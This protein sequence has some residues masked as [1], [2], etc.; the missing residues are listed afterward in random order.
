[1]DRIPFRG[2]LPV[3]SWFSIVHWHNMG[4]LFGFLSN[5]SAG[6]YVFLIIPIVIMAALGYYLVAYRHSLWS[7][8]GLTLVLSGAI[9]NMYDRIVFGYV[10]DFLDVFYRGFHWP[11]FNVA[12][13]AISV[14]IGLWLFSQLFC[15]P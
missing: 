12:D 5:H 2:E 9:G 14:G 13:S 7:R 3:F 10:V 6:R 1:V 11:A 8:L 4:G 15:E